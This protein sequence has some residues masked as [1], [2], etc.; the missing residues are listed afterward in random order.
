MA[1]LK[2]KRNKG[3]VEVYLNGVSDEKNV[4]I[5]IKLWS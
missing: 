2:T 5:V 3:D 4:R 1:Y